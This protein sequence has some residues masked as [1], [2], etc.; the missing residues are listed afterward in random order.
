MCH[1]LMKHTRNDFMRSLCY[2][3]IREQEYEILKMNEM[4]DKFNSWQYNSNLI[5]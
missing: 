5:I 3:I 2:D 4:L 1:R